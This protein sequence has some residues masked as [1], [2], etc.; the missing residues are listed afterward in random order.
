MGI[1]N[2][3]NE[4]KDQQGRVLDVKRVLL[5]AIR[6]AI[7]SHDGKLTYP[8]V[9]MALVEILKGNLLNELTEEIADHSS[10]SKIK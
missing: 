8:E 3:T 10:Q 5:N 1:L 4:M 6:N 7:K 9:N 2:I